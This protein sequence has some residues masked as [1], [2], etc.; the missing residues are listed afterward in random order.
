MRNIQHEWR[1]SDVHTYITKTGMVFPFFSLNE[2]ANNSSD[3]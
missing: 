3:T 2:D 1:R